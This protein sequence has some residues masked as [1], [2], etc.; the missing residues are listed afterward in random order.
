MTCYPQMWIFLGAVA[1][2]GICAMCVWV[3]WDARGEHERAN[4]RGEAN[5]RA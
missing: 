1:F 4:S 3:G 5:P 2:L